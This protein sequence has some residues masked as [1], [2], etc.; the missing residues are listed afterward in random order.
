MTDP[1]PYD[2]EQM[3]TIFI[4]HKDQ[5]FWNSRSPVL[6]PLVPRDALNLEQRHSVSF[7]GDAGKD[8]E[9]PS[10]FVPPITRSQAFAPKGNAISR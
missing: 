9:A 6:D 5:K 7:G 8:S 4:D 3:D 10:S 2:R 1:P